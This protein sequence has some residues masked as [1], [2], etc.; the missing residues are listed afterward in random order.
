MASPIDDVRIGF[1]AC[2]KLMGENI[3]C[4]LPVDHGGDCYGWVE[5]VLRPGEHDWAQHWPGN[6]CRACG[7]DDPV[8]IAC[9]TGEAFA[10]CP[11]K[12][13]P[14][15]DPTQNNGCQTCS[16]TGVIPREVEC[17][18]CPAKPVIP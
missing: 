7:M 6:F 15:L 2:W 16:G 5:P 12:C 3:N 9:G 11:E 8:E 10:D 14:H 13:R 4:R 17:S 1:H 18:P